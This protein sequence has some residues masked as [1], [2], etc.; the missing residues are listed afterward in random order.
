MPS[1]CVLGFS[2]IEIYPTFIYF[3]ASL[4]MGFWEQWFVYLSHYHKALGLSHSTF[5]EIV[6]KPYIT[7]L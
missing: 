3:R 6:T 7:H 1:E 4:P 2:V 5:M